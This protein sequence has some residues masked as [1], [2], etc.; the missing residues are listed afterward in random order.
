[1]RCERCG[2]ELPEEAEFCRNCGHSLKRESFLKKY[3]FPLA[4]AATAIIL[5]IIII[6][7]HTSFT[8]SV[9]QEVQVDNFNFA[10]PNEFLEDL[11]ASS[12]ENDSGIITSSKIWFSPNDAI[13]I[14]AMHS[15]DA[16]IDANIVNSQI[17]GQKKDMLGY[18][19]FFRKDID[20][21]SFSFVK[22]N[23]LITIYATNEGLFDEITIL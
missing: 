1:M 4:I 6:T 15:D 21:S 19:G 2:E 11:N 13:R 22:N 7:A 20:V 18:S 9:Y 23:T 16:N 10:I 17:G 5:A 3:R 8:D 14:T 12:T